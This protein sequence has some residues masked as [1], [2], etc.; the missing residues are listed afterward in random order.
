MQKTVGVLL[1]YAYSFA[2]FKNA[3]FIA[4]LFACLISVAAPAAEDE[5]KS[6]QLPVPRFVT[7]GTDEINLRTGPGLRYPIKLVIKKDGLPV[8]V[9]REFDVWRQVRDMDGDEGWVHKSMLSG[10]RAVIIK[11]Q[12]QSLLKKP[13][14]DARPVAKLEPGVIASL[15]TCDKE[16]CELT[17]A[18]Y[19]GWLKRDAVWGVYADETFGSK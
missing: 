13:A 15:K 8:E 12:V 9:I 1:F 18:V 11:G 7:L 10:R 6:A 4:L 5:G 16:W 14:P 17:V 2:M 19:T 3:F